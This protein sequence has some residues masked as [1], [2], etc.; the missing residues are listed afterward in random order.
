MEVDAEAVAVW[1]TQRAKAGLSRASNLPEL[2][3][4]A[5][6]AAPEIIQV[7][8]CKGCDSPILFAQFMYVWDR[9]RYCPICDRLKRAFLHVKGKTADRADVHIRRGDMN[10]YFDGESLVSVNDAKKTQGTEGM[11][12]LRRHAKEGLTS[13]VEPV[14]PDLSWYL[15]KIRVP[16]AGTPRFRNPSPRASE[17]EPGIGD[18]ADDTDVTCALAEVLDM[19]VRED[20]DDDDE[21]SPGSDD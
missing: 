19:Y 12:L 17:T 13:Y 15:R 14:R 5:S 8:E 11:K 2:A 9:V 16:P 4:R 1:R 18:D 7:I 6:Q 3:A 10:R 20:N 21:A